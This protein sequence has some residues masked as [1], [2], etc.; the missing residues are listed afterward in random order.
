MRITLKRNQPNVTPGTTGIKIPRPQYNVKK[1]IAKSLKSSGN[2]GKV[3]TVMRK[4]R[5]FIKAIAQD[6]PAKEAKALAGFS[7][8]TTTAAIMA[9]PVAQGILDE[10]LNLYPTLTKEGIASRLDEWWKHPDFDR[11]KESMNKVLELRGY[12]KSG[13]DQANGVTSET[14]TQIV[15]NV[16]TVPPP[17]PSEPKQVHEPSS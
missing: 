14:P 16:L 4:T 7:S 6:V 17:Q 13:L 9:S 2:H 15:F 11:Q 1:L 12:K 8:Q 3:L 10:V 5:A